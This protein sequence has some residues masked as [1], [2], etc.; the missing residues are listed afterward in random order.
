MYNPC[1]FAYRDSFLDVLL[2][3]HVDLSQCNGGLDGDC[4]GSAK[5]LD[6]RITILNGQVPKN[7]ELA[8]NVMLQDVAITQIKDFDE[9][10]TELLVSLMLVFP[11]DP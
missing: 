10:D 11:S 2:T 5:Y 6:A 7:G 1:L 3:L 9:F 4:S 8:V